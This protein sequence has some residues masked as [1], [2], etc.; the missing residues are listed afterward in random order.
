MVLLRVTFVAFKKTKCLL[1]NMP[2]E[3]YGCCRCLNGVTKLATRRLFLRAPPGRGRG[4]PGQHQTRSQ[5][6]FFAIPSG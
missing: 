2:K 4:D 6:A 1:V 5:P 3:T